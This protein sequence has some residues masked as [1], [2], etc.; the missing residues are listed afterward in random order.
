[1][2]KSAAKGPAQP[3]VQPHRCYDW[4]LVSGNCHYTRDR[5]SF[6]TYRHIGEIVRTLKIFGGRRDT[7]VAGVGT[8]QLEVC[9][10]GDDGTRKR[11][12]VLENV[13]HLPH[14]LC[15]GFN[16]KLYHDST[17]GEA[18]VGE[19]ECHGTD[20]KGKPLWHGLPFLG[21]RKLALVGIPEGSSYDPLNGPFYSGFDL[22]LR[23]RDLRRLLG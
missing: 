21:F 8:I 4:M 1:M 22:E 17:G 12:L 11:A 9:S 3:E 10:S 19:D 13:L 16:F 5:Y 15:H 2:P 23:D 14:A 6:K 18:T 7:F 20:K